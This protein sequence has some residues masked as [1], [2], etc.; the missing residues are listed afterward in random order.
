MSRFSPVCGLCP[1]DD[2]IY[3]EPLRVSALTATT[4]VIGPSGHL[5]SASKL[6]V[7]S[8][9]TSSLSAGLSSS[10]EVNLKFCT[11]EQSFNS[12]NHIAKNE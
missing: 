5:N 9:A 2:A 6:C 11:Q 4:N 10:S 12:G 7:R 3:F 1:T 8:K